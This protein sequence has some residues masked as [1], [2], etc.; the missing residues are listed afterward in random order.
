MNSNGTQ[1]QQAPICRAD[2]RILRKSVT[3]LPPVSFSFTVV[4]VFHIV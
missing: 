4:A 1:L 2:E 3:I